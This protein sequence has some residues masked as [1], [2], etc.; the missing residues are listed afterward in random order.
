MSALDRMCQ[1]E[2]ITVEGRIGGAQ[3]DAVVEVLGQVLE[4]DGERLAR[5]FRYFEVSYFELPKTHSVSG[6]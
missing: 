2:L 1:E 3:G 4:E 6:N 5:G